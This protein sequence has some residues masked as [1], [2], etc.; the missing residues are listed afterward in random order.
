MSLGWLSE[1]AL[2]PKR[3]KEIEDVSKASMVEMRAALYQSE[4]AARQP[5]GAASVV[6]SSQRKRREQRVDPLAGGV[7]VRT[8]SSM[9]NWVALLVWRN[10]MRR[11]AVAGMVP[12]G[13][14]FTQLAVP[15]PVGLE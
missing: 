12:V 4:S 13:V 10:L 11:F 5:D 14:I 7:P 6:L 2:M 15:E 1:S 3:P 8:T 9:R